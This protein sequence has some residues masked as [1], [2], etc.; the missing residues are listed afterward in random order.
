[1]ALLIQVLIPIRGSLVTANICVSLMH[2]SY[3]A[4][5]VIDMVRNGNNQVRLLVASCLW[6]LPW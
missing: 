3:L 6:W 1:M 4:T 2:L 5:L